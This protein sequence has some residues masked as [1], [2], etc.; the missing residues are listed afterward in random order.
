MANFF[1]DSNL[2]TKIG[3]DVVVD[4]DKNLA[5]D[6]GTIIGENS[7]DNVVASGAGSV[8]NSG[9][10]GVVQ[11]EDSAVLQGGE[12]GNDIGAF[13]FGSGSATNV[14]DSNLFGSA[15]G[16]S[17]PVQQVVGNDASHG[18]AVSGSGPAVADNDL[19]FSNEENNLTNIENSSNVATAQ[20]DS[21]TQ[22]DQAD[23]DVEDS[24]N[25]FTKNQRFSDDDTTVNRSEDVDIDDF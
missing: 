22:A 24:F 11:A 6:G 8:A 14:Q 10:G 5:T 17:G 3:G 18:G 15:V 25:E 2:G 19:T 21:T 16:N 23:V 1:E 12:G 4:N 7:D 9:S 13:S 20:D